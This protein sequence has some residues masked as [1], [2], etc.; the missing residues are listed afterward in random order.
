MA[1]KQNS[2]TIS[3]MNELHAAVAV[4]MLHR[5]RS[6]QPPEDVEPDEEGELPFFIPLA[7][8]ELQVMVS[9]LN[10]NDI[11]ATPDTEALV[12]LAQEF[13]KDLDAARALKATNIV[14]TEDDGIAAF[15]N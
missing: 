14:K 4:Y 11:T 6:S 2:A 7:A 3:T 5:I 8:S 13:K 10:N 1:K 9:F 15:L 12:E